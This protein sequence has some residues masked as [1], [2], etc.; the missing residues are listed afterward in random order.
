MNSK[1]GNL[2]IRRP[3]FEPGLPLPKQ[4]KFDNLC[5][6]GRLKVRG[7]PTQAK[8]QFLS[9]FWYVPK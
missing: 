5:D 6:A 7:M 4:H 3:E 9:L 1:I 2:A 8:N